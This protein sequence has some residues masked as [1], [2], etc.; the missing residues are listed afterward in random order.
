MEDNIRIRAQAFSNLIRRDKNKRN[1]ELLCSS[2]K[3]LVPFVGAGI[4][5]W[6]Y[7]MW[8]EL[9]EDVVKKNFSPDCAKIVGKA[10]RCGRD[11]NKPSIRVEAVEDTEGEKEVFRW[12]EEIAEYIFDTDE[13][14]FRENKEKFKLR[15]TASRQE[16][17]KQNVA[18]TALED[19]HRYLGGYG[20]NTRQAAVK[21]LYKAFDI[22]K[23]KNAGRFPEYQKFFPRLFPSLLVTTNYDKALEHCYPSIFSYSYSDLGTVDKQKKSWLYQAVVEKLRQMQDRLSG[24]NRPEGIVIPDI[25][26]LLKIHGSIEQATN[27]ALSRAGYKAVYNGE[28]PELFS[29]IC[30]HSSLLFMGCGLREDRILDELK[31]QKIEAE[32]KGDD[33]FRHFTFYSEPE[34]QTKK[35]NLEKQFQEY[36]IYPIY[37]RKDALPDSLCEPP[38]RGEADYHNICL[39]I[40]LENLLRRKMH[41]HQP[42]EELWN[43]RSFIPLEISGGMK[44]A[45]KIQSIIEGSQYVH[46]EEATQIWE[47]LKSSAE[48][49]L[50]AVTGDTGS[51]KSTFCQNIQMLNK[52][53]RDE[54]QFFYISLENCKTWNEFCIQAYQNLNIVHTEIKGVREWRNVAERIEQRCNGYWRSV[55]IFDHLDELEDESM[56][57]GQWDAIRQMLDYWR[58]H[59]LRVIFTTRTYPRGISCYMWRIGALTADEAK[60]VFFSA[61]VSR[62]YEN[63]PLL[64]QNT[65][66]TLFSKHNFQ[67]ASA[68]LLGRYADSKND[69]ATLLQEWESCHMQGY[70]EEHTL[71]R[72][73]WNHLLD[74]HQWAD[75]SDAEKENIEKNILWIWG[76]LGAYP[77]IFPKAFF[78]GAWSNENEYKSKELSQKNLIYMKNAGLCEETIDEKYGFLLEKM[79]HCARLFYHKI[80]EH[81]SLDFTVDSRLDGLRS[82]YGYTMDKYNG[83]LRRHSL[84]EWMQKRTQTTDFDNTADSDKIDAAN[85]ILTI[86]ETLGNKV[87]TSEGRKSHKDLNL[88]L[89]YEIKTVISFLFTQLS[90]ADANKDDRTRMRILNIG[91]LFAH[92]YRYVPDHAFLMVQ[93]LLDAAETSSASFGLYK[94]SNLYKIMGDI[95]RL[96]GRKAD[97]AKC[98]Q[99]AEQL[100][101]EEM[102][103]SFNNAKVSDQE[104]QR[105]VDPYTESQRIK[106]DLL[107]Q[108]HYVRLTGSDRM[109]DDERRQKAEELEKLCTQIEDN[110][111]K[112]KFNQRMGEIL[113]EEESKNIEK[114]SK[115]TQSELIDSFNKVRRHYNFAAEHY[116]KA[117]DMTGL[118]YILKCMGDLIGVYRVPYQG[119]FHLQK[120]QNQ[121]ID[122]YQIIENKPESFAGGEDGISAAAR[123]YAQAFTTYCSHINWRGFANVLQGMGNLLRYCLI[124]ETRRKGHLE[125][126]EFREVEVL[127]E[128][129]EGFYRWLGDMRGLADTLDYAGYAY[130][131]KGGDVAECIALGKWM[132]SKEIWENLENEE[133]VNNIDERIN[134]LRQKVNNDLRS[135]RQIEQG[136]RI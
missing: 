116:G 3:P 96:L 52:N 94:Q 47:L 111:S 61:C 19:L 121:P 91:Y 97:A 50:I 30:Q 12:M 87:E 114:G 84:K 115:N 113:Y 72:L 38:G 63:S 5:S 88:V 95:H 92:Y 46:V 53:P 77:G 22:A 56:Y 16:N 101:G 119:K 126:G 75:K 33:S 43:K 62:W 55:L 10:L 74:E 112:A 133:K 123:C 23:L 9:L 49:P 117:G 65:L 35:A 109:R 106:L 86:L 120:V 6:C 132:E 83:D 99:K 14:S 18:N 73:I 39:G 127:F 8:D 17:S 15:E 89:H 105:K 57:P 135:K 122:Y 136:G 78:E 21:S 82:F 103:R 4:S 100:C 13:I 80:K 108:N 59:Q 118:A 48:C 34:T 44:D 125:M 31:K 70:S 20:V 107:L 7:P 2:D 29:Y 37:Y 27:I 134:S 71:A 41:Y 58:E 76:I 85:S 98:Y 128:Y 67:P 1:W 24:I 131:E 36:G 64:E 42:L 32:K 40:L 93:H 28:M 129:A 81:Q 79:M 51:G 124:E 66:D 68:Y 45:A 90:R 110:W 25:P 54:M 60:K 26:M 104:S 69:F 130:R 11:G 102:L